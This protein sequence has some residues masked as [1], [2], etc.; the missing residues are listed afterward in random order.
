M[1]D[2]TGPWTIV[3]PEV[4][5]VLPYHEEVTA[6]SGTY[7][8]DRVYS[9]NSLY[10]PDITSTGHQP[11]GFDQ[12]GVFYDN[13]RVIQ[14]SYQFRVNNAS[15]TSGLSVYLVV[16]NDPTPITSTPIAGENPY[17]QELIVGAATGNDIRTRTAVYNLPQLFGRTLAQYR[18]EKDYTGLF[19]AAPAEQFYLHVFLRTSDGVAAL[20]ANYTLKLNYLTEIFERKKL[21]LS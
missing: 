7:F 18:T 2:L 1:V 19:S 10:D 20:D 15:T 4:R 8:A 11:M 13:Y 6:T 21:P 9:L 16:S 3:P 14:T 5:T 12:W 17:T